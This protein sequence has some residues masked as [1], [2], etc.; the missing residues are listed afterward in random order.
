M[1]ATAHALLVAMTGYGSKADQQRA[2]DAGFDHYF[3]KPTDPS[4]LAATITQ[5]RQAGE[6]AARTTGTRIQAV[7]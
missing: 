6:A 2:Q 7:P 5:W 4:T 3:V 1:P